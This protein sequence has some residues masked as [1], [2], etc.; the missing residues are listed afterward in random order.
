MFGE[1]SKNHNSFQHR[2]P[3][4]SFKH[5]EGSGGDLLAAQTVNGVTQLVDP[6]KKGTYID[7]LD[8]GRKMVGDVRALQAPS[9]KYAPLDT[10]VT[11]YPLRFISHKTK[12]A[13]TTPANFDPSWLKRSSVP[14]DAELQRG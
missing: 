9:Q 13:L 14:P 3:N 11:P 7:K 8:A 2:D 1:Q 4:P 6:C 12:T 5:R 10:S